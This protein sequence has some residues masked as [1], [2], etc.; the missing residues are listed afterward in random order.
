MN[1]ETIKIAFFDIDG[2]LLPF[3]QAEPSAKI[4]QTLQQLRQQGIL[5]F[6]A[7]GRPSYI[8]PDFGFDGMICCNG[9]MA[10]SADGDVLFAHALQPQT[11]LAVYER[12]SK[13]GHGMIFAGAKDMGADIYDKR[14]DDYMISASQR[15][16][17]DPD[18]ARRF[19]QPCFQVMAAL[20]MEERETFAQAIPG[21]DLTSWHPLACDITAAGVSKGEAVRAVCAFYGIP[22]S[23]SIAFGDAANDLSMLEAAGISV[24]MGNAQEIVK[25]KADTVTETVQEDGVRHEFV[26]RGYISEF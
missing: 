9:A 1:N 5:V 4:L 25:E 11:L 7:S 13:A 10:V 3:H 8:L 16:L 20:P 15:A 23:A 18:F 22:V 6:A 14:L 17:P 12:L 26:R 19:E 24:A 21:V 2:T